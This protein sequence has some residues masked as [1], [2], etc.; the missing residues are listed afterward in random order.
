MLA[1]TD[2]L[3]RYKA[4]ALLLLKSQSQHSWLEIKKNVK[5]ELMVRCR[6]IAEPFSGFSLSLFDKIKMTTAPA[7]D[8]IFPGQL[9]ANT[10]FAFDGKLIIRGGFCS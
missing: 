5:F 2:A 8:K 6:C 3:R 1:A 4:S 10:E 9:Q 7:G